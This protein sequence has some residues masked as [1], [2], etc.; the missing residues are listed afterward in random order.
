M[1][2]PNRIAEQYTE[3]LNLLEVS[4]PFLSLE[5]FLDAFPH[6]LGEDEVELRRRLR[7]AYDEWQDNQGGLQP[8]P[9]IHAAWVRFVLTDVL[10]MPG[11]V[12]AMGTALPAD[13]QVTMAQHGE[14]LRPDIAVMDPETKC[15]RLLIQSVPPQQKLDKALNGQ[16]WPASPTMRM[17]ELLRATNVR[18]G[19]VTNGEQWLLVNAPRNETTGYVTWYS[20]LWLE[21]KITLLAW[22]S[23]LGVHRFFSVPERETLEGLLARSKA[24]QQEVTDR[25]GDQVRRAVEVLVRAIDLANRDAANQLLIGVSA[26]ELYEAALT[27]MMRLVF[28]FA[29]EERGLFPL[30]DPLYN[31]CYAASPLRAQL[32]E[33][34]DAFGEEVIERRTDAWHRLLATFR[35]IF[36]GI[37]HD[38]LRLPAYGSSMFD[39]DRFPFLEG[40]PA[41]STWRTTP[42]R[43]LPINNRTVLHLLEALQMLQVKTPSGERQAQRLS[44]RALDI[45]QIGQVY[46]GLL[47][48]TVAQATEPVVGLSGAQ[49][50]EPEVPLAF[51]EAHQRQGE[52]ALLDWLAEQTGRSASA[53]RKAL[54]SPPTLLQAAQLR[55]ACGNQETL[56][57]RVLP[58]AGLIRTDDLGQPVVILPGSFYVTAGQQ[59]RATGTHYTPRT[60]TEPIVQHTL[61]PLVYL[62]PA[63]GKPPTQWQLRP[64]A[65]LLQL[66]ICDMAMGS[67]AFHVQVCRYLAERI[68]EAWEQAETRFQ[69]P[70]SKSPNRITITGEP[71]HD[72]NAALPADTEERL[73][74]AKRLVAERCL[75]GVDKN[76]LAVEMAKLSIW[77][78]T[79]DKGRPFTFLDHAFKCGDS[80]VGVNLDQLRCWNLAGSGARQFGT[81]GIDLD[82]QKMVKLRQEIE[83]MPMLDIHDQE[84]KAY[85]LTQAE[86]LAHDLKTAGDLLV[87]SYYNNLGK[88]EQATLRTALLAAVRNGASVEAKWRQQADLGELRPFHWPLEFPE[89]FLAEGRSGFDAFVGNP[90]FVGGQRIRAVMSEK[91]LFYLK[92]RWNHSR[93]SADYSAYFFLRAFQNLQVKGTFGL[94]ATNT[95]AQ[96]DTRELGLEHICQHTGVIYQAKNNHPWPGQASVA[97]NIVH[98]YKGTYKGQSILDEQ[99]VSSIT[100]L[101]DDMSTS[102][103][104]NRL[105]LNRDKSF[106]GYNLWGEGFIITTEEAQRLIDLNEQNKDVVLPYLNGAELNTSIDMAPE[107]WAINFFDWALDRAEKYPKPIEIVREKVKPIRDKV[108]RIRNR[109]YWWQYA[110][111]RPGLINAIKS[112]QQ[113]L[114]CPQT[115]KYLNFI[116][117]TTNWVFSPRLC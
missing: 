102:G 115:T 95:I 98:I 68:V 104:P 14:T 25:L 73:M 30:D 77:L 3:L 97:V 111:T 36:A 10:G 56:T 46:E 39:P 26:S 84:A 109:E 17:T 15:A 81:V 66:K 27:L 59:R 40:R 9:A 105:I 34:A 22:R 20:E 72:L 45:E 87:A 32:R 110:E 113:V 18:L 19:L 96:G 8:N 28:L 4:G 60:L 37:E 29:A 117:V 93:G 52:K 112:K 103:R 79:M 67:G 65:A 35:A 88:Q 85:K 6:G 75:Y 31:Q 48:H 86:A 83:T 70:K 108:N 21:E 58:F 71:T 42:A 82:I 47:D 16:H 63:E 13:L 38:R 2:R 116:F 78:V 114:V 61:E 54:T 12:L 53:L 62:G 43:P 92:T 49:G 89:V 24:D 76:P 41:H 33:A 90:P 1:S 101:L 50:R 44:F 7:L 51:L 57:M 107:R 100:P 106:L 69:N 55:A 80:L 94:I 99:N 11:D 5:V 74:L 91:Y 23:L 64:A